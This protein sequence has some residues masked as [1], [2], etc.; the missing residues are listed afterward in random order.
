MTQDPGFHLSDAITARR[1]RIEALAREL[2]ELLAGE[3]PPHGVAAE[4]LEA[5]ED[6]GPDMHTLLAAMTSLT[7]EVRL[8]GRAFSELR[9]ALEEAETRNQQQ[10]REGEEGIELAM[11]VAERLDRLI[12][13]TAALQETRPRRRRWFFLPTREEPAAAGL[14]EGLRLVRERIGDFLEQRGFQRLD[15]LSRPFDP[16]T[17]EAVE[18]EESSHADDGTVVDVYKEGYL[19]HGELHRAAKVRVARRRPPHPGKAD[20]PQ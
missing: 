13:T 10:E 8:Q 16:R 3:D 2:E 14:H 4:F 11:D 9:A 1:E 5:N 18:V 20:T 6:P 12:A 7:Q 15:A 19:R 17:M